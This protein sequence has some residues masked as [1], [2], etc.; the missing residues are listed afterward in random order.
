MRKFLPSGPRRYALALFLL[1]GSLLL[2][3]SSCAPTKEQPPG[4]G[5]SINP[6]QR[7]FTAAGQQ[8]LF[9]VTNNSPNP[10]GVLATAI[11][12][13]GNTSE[14]EFP[15]SLDSCNGS[16]LPAGGTCSFTDTFQPYDN[17]FKQ[18]ALRVSDGTNLTNAVVVGRCTSCASKPGP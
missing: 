18:A 2:M 9:T 6:T 17:G 3:G 15:I 13:I 1:G 8:Q 16:V 12:A 10:T 4:G 14:D 11:E 5:L 7:N